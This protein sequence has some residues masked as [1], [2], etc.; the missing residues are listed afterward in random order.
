MLTEA[1]FELAGRTEFSGSQRWTLPELAGFARTLSVL[2][3]EALAANTAAFDDSLAA[4]LGPY[5]RDG[6]LTEA[7]SFVYEL[8]RKAPAV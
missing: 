2:P 8:A 4:E 1:G 7:V 6:Y 3:T 5:L